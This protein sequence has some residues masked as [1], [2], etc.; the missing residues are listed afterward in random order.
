MANQYEEYEDDDD[1]DT[2][3]AN[4]PANLRKALKRAE[5][6]ASKLKDELA[7]LRSESRTRTVKDVLETKGVNPKIAAFI[8]AD[9]DTPEK[10]ALW[11]DEYSDV[12]GYQ[13]NEQS[14]DIV[15]PD[16]ARRIQDSTS[17]ADTSSRDEDLGSRLAATN[18]KEELDQLI[19]GMSTGR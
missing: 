14:D 10:V 4:G 13:V 18:S 5:R 1:F 12:F 17:S 9:A 6:E 2:E 8:P 19:F 15:A 16:S 7:S 3:E 11:L